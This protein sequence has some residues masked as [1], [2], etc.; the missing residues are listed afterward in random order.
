MN[1]SIICACAPVIYSF[2]RSRVNGN[3]STTTS[4]YKKGA[5]SG[6]MSIGSSRPNYFKRSQVNEDEVGLS[7]SATYHTIAE[8]DGETHSLR[9]LDS[10]RVHKSFQV[11]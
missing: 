7:Q 8:P 1:L 11:T 6:V 5:T 4:S 10:I 3:G 2:I 9:A